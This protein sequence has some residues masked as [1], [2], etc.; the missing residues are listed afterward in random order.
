MPTNIVTV[1]GALRFIQKRLL[2][3]PSLRLLSR[4][5]RSYREG[6]KAATKKPTLEIWPHKHK[7][8]I[9]QSPTLR[10]RMPQKNPIS[11]Q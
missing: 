6:Q 2:L 11:F 5:N 9:F 1:V 4:S 3:V 10:N 7:T 8:I